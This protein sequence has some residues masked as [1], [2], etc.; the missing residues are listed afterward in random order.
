MSEGAKGGND[1]LISGFG[2]DTMY[3]DAYYL[4][5]TSTGGNDILNAA[6]GGKNG[7]EDTLYGDASSTLIED[8]TPYT[9]GTGGAD[10]FIVGGN[11]GAEIHDY[12]AAEGD[13]VAGYNTKEYLTTTT[14]TANS[15]NEQK[16]TSDI[17]NA[18]LLK[19]KAK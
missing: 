13:R 9:R 10:L 6:V 7:G 8:G 11:T 19:G 17:L 1:R 12:S 3:G 15:A 18:I 5:S 14:S 2:S 4:D 16:Q